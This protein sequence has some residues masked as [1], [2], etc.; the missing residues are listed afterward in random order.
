MKKCQE[1]ALHYV[2]LNKTTVCMMQVINLIGRNIDNM[3]DLNRMI[4]YLKTNGEKTF[5]MQ[6]FMKMEMGQVVFNLPNYL[7]FEII[8]EN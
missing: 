2:D 1:Y 7:D 4:N 8:K 3:Q 5:L 6:K